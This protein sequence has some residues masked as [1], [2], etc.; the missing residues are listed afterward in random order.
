MT[1]LQKLQN[2]AACVITNSPIDQ[3]LM[4]LISQMYLSGPWCKTLY[5][6][7]VIKVKRYA[8]V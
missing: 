8:V 3:T 1:F 6:A 7:S 4:P 2:H 5:V